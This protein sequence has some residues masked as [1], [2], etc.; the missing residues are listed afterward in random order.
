[1]L[2]ERTKLCGASHQKEV[3]ASYVY[4]TKEGDEVPL[5]DE[6]AEWVR[7][8]NKLLNLSALHPRATS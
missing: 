7:D 2:N 3:A 5:C 8:M 1:M 4:L 6:H